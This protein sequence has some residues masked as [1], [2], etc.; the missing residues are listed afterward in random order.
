MYIHIR[1]K[2]PTNTSIPEADIVTVRDVQRIVVE[3]AAYYAARGTH[4]LAN[5][6]LNLC[7]ICSKDV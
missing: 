2:R 1:Q 6:E 7:K 5:A 4:V 3:L